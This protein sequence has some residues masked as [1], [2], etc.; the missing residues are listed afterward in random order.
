MIKVDQEVVDVLMLYIEMRVNMVLN[1][2]TDSLLENEW[3][4]FCWYT[5]IYDANN[6]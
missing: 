3:L 6:V 2:A 4:R 5:R 1:G